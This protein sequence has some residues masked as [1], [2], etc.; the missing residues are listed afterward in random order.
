MKIKAKKLLS[1]IVTLVMTITIMSVCMVSMTAGAAAA[2]EKRATY[3]GFKEYYVELGGEKFTGYILVPE[4]EGKYPVNVI[5]CG[6]GG[7][8]RWKQYNFDQ[9][10]QQWVTDGYVQPSIIVMPSTARNNQKMEASVVGW[11]FELTVKKQLGRM[12]EALLK[13]P[14]SSRIDPTK[15]ISISGY[16]MG[17]AA[18]LLTGSLYPNLYANIGALSCSHTY[19][20]NSDSTAWLTKKKAVVFSKSSKARRLLSYS[21]S[22]GDIFKK[23][24]D[25]YNSVSRDNGYK[26]KTYITKGYGHN[27]YLFYRQIFVYLY[28]LDHNV[29]L[30][31]NMLDAMDYGI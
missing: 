21:K 3:N 29:V 28:Y 20:S 25:L 16:S 8:Q 17:G 5:Y 30:T 6:T 11:E 2:D 23:S 31:D 9:L 15:E 7:L 4:E 14:Y 13:T 1:L 24:F 27:V 19:Y 22:E 26:F 10:Y 18:A 12:K